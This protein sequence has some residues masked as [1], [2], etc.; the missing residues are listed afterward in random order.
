MSQMLVLKFIR[1]ETVRNVGGH[2]VGISEEMHEVKLRLLSEST[3]MGEMER[4]FAFEQWINTNT[5]G[6]L[7]LSVESAEEQTDEQEDNHREVERA[8]GSTQRRGDERSGGDG[9]SEVD[10]ESARG[11]SD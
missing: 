2:P 11:P 3:T 4:I 8:G 7:H 1:K 6:R 9:E 5:D 10:P